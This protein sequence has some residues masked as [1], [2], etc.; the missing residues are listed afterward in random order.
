MRGDTASLVAKKRGLGAQ[1]LESDGKKL[2]CGLYSGSCA[3]M[4]TDAAEAA[5]D[6]SGSNDAATGG[7]NVAATKTNEGEAYRGALARRGD[8][9]SS[10]AVLNGAAMATP[11]ST[12][13]SG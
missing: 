10:S 4:H 12:T 7:I 2:K 9:A 6:V 3:P 1:G 8:D 5:T 13:R 11:A